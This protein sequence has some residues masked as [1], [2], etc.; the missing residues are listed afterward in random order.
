M[1]GRTVPS[2]GGLAN[3]IN[4]SS[5]IAGLSPHDRHGGRR[6]EPR[7]RRVNR[8]FH[9]LDVDHRNATALERRRRRR[10]WSH[11]GTRTVPRR[12]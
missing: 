11:F 2:S 10:R 3:P 12:V 8:R 1:E 6:R 4:G 9:I 7:K 5:L